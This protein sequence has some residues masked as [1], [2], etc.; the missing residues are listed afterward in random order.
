MTSSQLLSL[1]LNYRHINTANIIFTTVPTYPAPKGD[2][3][4]EH[5]YWSKDE[6]NALFSDIHDDIPIPVAPVRTLAASRCRARR[7]RS[8]C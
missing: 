1:G 2:P 8:R 3:F 4:Y 7:S 5:L 6:A